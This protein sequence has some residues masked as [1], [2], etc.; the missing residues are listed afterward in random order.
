MIKQVIVVRKD[1][2]MRKGKIASQ[3]AHA[4]MGAIMRY[5]TVEDVPVDYMADYKYINILAD[6]ALVEW[7]INGSFTKICVGCDSEEELLE[8][9]NKV[10]E[11]GIR[12]YSLIQDNGTTEFN[13]VKTYTALAIGPALSEK[14]DK[15]TG[16]LKL[17]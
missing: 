7:L 17:L 15:I 13:G 9:N 16:H 12:N 3:V 11:S 5:H 2:N 4:S 1:L 8:L 6:P 10:K 14:I